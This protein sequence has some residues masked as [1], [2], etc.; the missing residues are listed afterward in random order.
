[1]KI[2]QF[3]LSLKTRTI[4]AGPKGNLCRFMNHC[5]DPNCETQ[6]WMV[7]GD[8]RVGLFALVDIP[9]SKQII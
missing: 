2:K 7:N 6:K 5:C 1:M 8:I 3:A 4:D 9:A